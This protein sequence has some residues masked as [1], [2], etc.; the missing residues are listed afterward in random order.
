MPCF[1][2]DYRSVRNFAERADTVVHWTEVPRGGHFAAL[3]APDLLVADMRK[4]FG[5]L[6]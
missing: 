4:F 3:D 5:A 2:R 6:Q 1:P